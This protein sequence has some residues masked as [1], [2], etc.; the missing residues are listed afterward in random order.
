LKSLSLTL[1]QNTSSPAA[2]AVS[3]DYGP[4]FTV[5]VTQG[6]NAIPLQAAK[7]YQP[8]STVVRINVEGWQN[9]R[10]ELRSIQINQVR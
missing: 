4:F 10:V 3:I 5:N 9:N 2:V 8:G 6:V 1:G 7:T